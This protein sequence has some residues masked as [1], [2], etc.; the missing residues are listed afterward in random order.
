[1]T[2]NY[3]PQA[4][5]EKRNHWGSRFLTSVIKS[6]KPKKSSPGQMSL[7]WDNQKVTESTEVHEVAGGFMKC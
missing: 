3:R 4:K 7:P 5:P 6:A 1:M 2:N